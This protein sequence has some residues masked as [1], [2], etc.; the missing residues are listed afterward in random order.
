M[1]PAL[2]V[3]VSQST[4]VLVVVV[5]GTAAS[6]DMGVSILMISVLSLVQWFQ[7]RGLWRAG[8]AVDFESQ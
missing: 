7:A 4:A 1:A 2:V 6:V 5:V 3:L 8:T